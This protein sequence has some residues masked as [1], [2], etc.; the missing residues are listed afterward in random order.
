MS[1]AMPRRAVHKDKPRIVA[2]LQFASRALAQND[3]VVAEDFYFMQRS[4]LPRRSTLPRPGVADEQVGRAGWAHNSDSM[5]LNRPLLGE[6]VRDQEL[7]QGI[8]QRIGHL[9]INREVPAA[10]LKGC[11]TKMLIHHQSLTRSSL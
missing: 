1:L 9:R 7:V 10:H 8:A 3:A 5:Q 2:R 6:P 4:P 11:V